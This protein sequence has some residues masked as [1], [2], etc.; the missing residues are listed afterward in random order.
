MEPTSQEVVFGSFR[1]CQRPYKCQIVIIALK[2][3]E[4]GLVFAFWN[5]GAKRISISTDPYA[6]GIF[7]TKNFEKNFM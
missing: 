4:V 2:Q 7:L 5:I 3:E 6:L 1:V